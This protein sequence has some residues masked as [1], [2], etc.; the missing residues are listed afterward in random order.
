MRQFRDT[1]IWLAM[2]GIVAGVIYVMPRV[3]N[4][5]DAAENEKTLPR[6]TFQ[7]VGLSHAPS[8]HASR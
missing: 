5:V 1:L 3:A 6:A 4:Y 2:I 8:N 7:Q